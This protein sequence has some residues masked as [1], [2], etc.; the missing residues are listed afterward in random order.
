MIHM[1]TNIN[2]FQVK[3]VP[4][5][6]ERLSNTHTLNLYEDTLF[7]ILERLPKDIDRKLID[8]EQ[9]EDYDGY[10]YRFIWNVPEPEEQY[11]KRMNQYTKD[12]EKYNTWLKDNQEQLD[13]HYEEKLVTFKE[14]EQK[15]LKKEIQKLQKEF[16]N[17]SDTKNKKDDPYEY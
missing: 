12:L 15:R 17:L 3:P 5:K 8:Y 11:L 7:N 6:P 14:S 13:K 10:H 4:K 1:G 9:Y 2:N 16:K